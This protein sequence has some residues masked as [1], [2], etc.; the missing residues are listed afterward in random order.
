M[1]YHAKAVHGLGWT[2]VVLGTISTV[3]GTAAVATMA[4]KGQPTYMHYIAGPIWSG[5]FVLI[6]GILGVCS[7]KK[8]TNKCLI[9]AFMVLGIFTILATFCSF[10]LAVTGAIIDSCYSYRPWNHYDYDYPD[11]VIDPPD[12][13]YEYNVTAWNSTKPPPIPV[14]DIAPSGRVYGGNVGCTTAAK[15]LLFTMSFSLSCSAHVSPPLYSDDDSCTT[16]AKA[17][18]GVSALLAFVELVLGFVVS[19]MCCCGLCNSTTP[20]VMYGPGV[21]PAQLMSN[22]QGGFILLQAVPSSQQF[23]AR[24]QVFL[25]PPGA[26]QAPMQVYY[27]AG[28]APPQYAQPGGVG[29]AAA[30]PQY[31]QYARTQATEAPPVDTKT[32][33]TA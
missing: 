20:H 23:G 3:L 19:I 17:L 24:Q 7:G 4:A 28:Q 27:T 31:A 11:Y 2:L 33:L 32:P 30:P 21:A 1:A 25:A 22:G 15:V 8:P 13:E 12:Y 16:T 9:V 26:P 5:V 10:G 6:T 14:P 29:A 18:H